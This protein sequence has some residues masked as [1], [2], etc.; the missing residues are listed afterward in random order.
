[1]RCPNCNSAQTQVLDS[2]MTT[3]S[4]RRRRYRCYDCGKRF[5]TYEFS[6]E[7]LDEDAIRADERDKT[8]NEVLKLIR[9]RRKSQ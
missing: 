8:F 5:T 4:R 3:G 2:R 1:M 6:E 9:D 7:A